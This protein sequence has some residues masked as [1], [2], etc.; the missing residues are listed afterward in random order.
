MISE[1]KVETERL[2]IGFFFLPTL[3]YKIRG[4]P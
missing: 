3:T 4:G 1:R 2:V